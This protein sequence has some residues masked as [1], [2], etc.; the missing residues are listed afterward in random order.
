[1]KVTFSTPL[2]TAVMLFLPLLSA[3]ATLPMSVDGQA[4]PSLA[5]MVERVQSSLV[6]I[7]ANTQTR[8][9]RE[10][11]DD[12]FFR[13]F[14]DQRR[15][16][17]Q[18]SRVYSTGVVIDDVQGL[19]LTN[20]H[21][22]RGV[23]EVT[24]ML[25]DGRSIVGQVLGKDVASDVALI[26]VNELGLN[27]ISI[28]DSS[29]LNAGDFVVSI[30]D[31]LG[32]ENTLTTGVV[33]AVPKAHSLQAHQHFIR[34]DAALGSG[35]LV[36]LRGELVGFNIA[37]TAKTAGNSR[38]GFSTPINIAMRIQQQLAEFGAPQRGF[39]AIQVQD[40]SDGLADAFDMQQFNGQK[41]GAVI[42]A[43]GEGSSAQKSGLLIGDVVLKAGSQ[44]ISRSNDL[45]NIIGRQ[46]A[47]DSLALTVIRSG[48]IMGINPIL[49]SSSR[50]SKVGSM[51]HHQLEGA[52]FKNVAVQQVSSNADAGV[53][54][55]HV[56][57]GS[58][59]W[60]HGVR[61]G[62]IIVAA[63]RREVRNLAALKESIRDKDV[64]MLNI[65]RGDGSL[66]L[67]LQ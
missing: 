18:T 56:K 20:E 11:F 10:Q 30:G 7:V 14:F 12:P 47:G 9:K 57:Q 37:K 32:E 52:T 27:A 17:K 36:N 13:R 50:A 53:V 38:I 31:P 41:G 21:S 43:V 4:L 15:A 51:V 54:V 24:V 3:N 65:V 61:Q 5:P 59:A 62:D 40:L 23:P 45:R 26:K 34:S 42:T 35:V 33:S 66:F 25:N 29:A 60:L 2:L 55:S 58:V 48:Q 39:L 19:I 16:N 46:F 63:N 22:V 44:N 64:L 6:S 28:G 1:M 49:E 8:N 67:L